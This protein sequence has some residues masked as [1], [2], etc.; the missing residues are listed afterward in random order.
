MRVGRP[1]KKEQK[2]NLGF[3]VTKTGQSSDKVSFELLF[4]L[5]SIVIPDPKV[6]IP[7]ENARL[8]EMIQSWSHEST[9]IDEHEWEEYLAYCE[10]AAWIMLQ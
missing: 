9:D 7:P 2:G 6:D 10:E 8:L 5:E 1:F 4:D 3:A